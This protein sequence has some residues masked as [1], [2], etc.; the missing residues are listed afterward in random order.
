MAIEYK[1]SITSMSCYPQYEG[2]TDVVV[3]ATWNCIGKQ[4]I[5]G[6]AFTSSQ[7]GGTNFKLGELSNFTPYQ[8]LT[9]EQVLGWCF[10]SNPTLKDNTE[11]AVLDNIETQV[12]PPIVYPP[13][14]WAPIPLL[15][16][17]G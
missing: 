13:L 11:K 3:S 16:V 9:E 12:N 17:T 15:N 10:E 2:E 8:D 7:I 5:D 4:M 1:W 6:K 14:P